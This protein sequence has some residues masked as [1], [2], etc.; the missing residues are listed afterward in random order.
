MLN[1]IYMFLNYFIKRQFAFL[2]YKYLKFRSRIAQESLLRNLLVSL[3]EKNN[4]EGGSCSTSNL[5]NAASVDQS[6][7]A[8]ETTSDVLNTGS[9]SSIVAQFASRSLSGR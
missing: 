8:G 9:G 7:T 6:R 3:D 1:V 2:C 4:C 5:S